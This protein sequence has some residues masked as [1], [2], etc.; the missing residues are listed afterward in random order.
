[1]SYEGESVRF[2]T[3]HRYRSIGF[4]DK[5]LERV[6]RGLTPPDVYTLRFEEQFLRRVN[7][8]MKQVV[9]LQTLGDPDFWR[10]TAERFRRDY[11]MVEKQR[12]MRPFDGTGNPLKALAV[13]G[14]A[15]GGRDSVLRSMR[16]AYQE[17]RKPPSTYYQH[18]TQVLNLWRERSSTDH[19]DLVEELDS[20]IEC[21]VQRILDDS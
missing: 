13:L 8:Q 4:Y 19:P 7:R 5:V 3:S 1:M 17:G 16:L 21:A 11:Y 6:S 9:T 18:R 12:L 10:R 14:L 20:L 2:Q 15:N